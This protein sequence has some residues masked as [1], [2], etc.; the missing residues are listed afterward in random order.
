MAK[1]YLQL[2]NKLPYNILLPV[3]EY[4][5]PGILQNPVNCYQADMAIY[6]FSIN[7]CLD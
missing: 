1:I 6:N 2:D 4:A 5:I 7:G 3:I